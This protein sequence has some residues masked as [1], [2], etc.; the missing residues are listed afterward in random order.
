MAE[1]LTPRPPRGAWLL[2][3]ILFLGSRALMVAQPGWLSDT[4]RYYEVIQELAK[5]SRLYAEVPFEYPPLAGL[6]IT[7]PTWMTETATIGQYRRAF[8]IEMLIF[9]AAAFLVVATYAVRRRLG[10]EPA[11][12]YTAY[13]A[14]LGPLIFDRFDIVVGFLI[15]VAVMLRRFPWN[16]GA[17]MAILVAGSFLKWIPALVAPLLLVFPIRQEPSRFVALT[18][19]GL[20]ATVLL[21]ALS[22]AMF[23]AELLSSLRYHQARGIEVESTWATIAHVR[24]FLGTPLVVEAGYGAQHL[25]GEAADTLLPWTTPTAVVVMLGV[26]AAIFRAWQRVDRGSLSDSSMFVRT[27]AVLLAFLATSRVLSPQFFLWVAPLVPLCFWDPGKQHARRLLALLFAACLGLT[28]VLF[29]ILFVPLVRLDPTAVAILAVRN[30]L[31]LGLFGFVVRE[32]LS[33]S[34]QSREGIVGG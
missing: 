6:I 15:L 9:D 8:A 4:I 14:L 18:F 13:G 10:V 29:S 32:L 30:A 21:T 5:G 3:A 28:T 12:A 22:F 27:L 34:P 17:S 26:Y 7:L 25:A 20:V 31:L 2:V 33:P 24:Y 16:G 1:A 23:G 11:I 19:G